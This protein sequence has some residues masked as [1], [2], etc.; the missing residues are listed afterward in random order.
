MK[1]LKRQ[2][3][4]LVTVIFWITLA[5]MAGCSEHT[6]SQNQ[7]QILQTDKA[8]VGDHSAE[9]DKQE[10]PGQST[11]QIDAKDPQTDELGA[12]TDKE[13]DDEFSEFEGE[14]KDAT[15]TKVFDPLEGYN[16]AMTT[17]N[18]RL[19]FWVLKPVAL[20]YRWLIPEPARRGI[21]RFFTNLLSPISIVNN[22]LQL[23]LKYAGTETLRFVTN[24]TIGIFGLWDPARE[25]FGLEPHI[26]DFGQT[27]GYYGVGAG[28]HLV[29]PFFGPSNLRDAFAM[30]PDTMYLDPKTVY[31][32]G[33]WNQV[34]AFVFENVNEASLRIGEY[35]S[36]KKDAV[37]LYLFLRD[38]YEQIRIK[39]IEE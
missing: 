20:G 23:K 12:A 37:D 17:F 31:I 36:I 29:L 4:V 7:Q 9:L 14:F 28:P 30:Y 18:D 15:K 22:L 27:L 10:D 39:E 13:A 8:I 34:G 25:W 21:G 26:E 3:P 33:T 1:L 2:Q 38:G 35:E 16:R 6:A 11:K 32:K 5:V 24:T 19:Y